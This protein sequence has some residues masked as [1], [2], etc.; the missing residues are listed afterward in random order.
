[1]RVHGVVEKE[2][3]RKEHIKPTLL[4]LA[5]NQSVNHVFLNFN[6]NVI[7][8]KRHHNPPELKQ[9]DSD[10]NPSNLF[11]GGLVA[12]TANVSPNSYICSEAVILDNVT[13]RS[14]S[15]ITSPRVFEGKEVIDNHGPFNGESYWRPI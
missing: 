1:M 7:E 2:V 3:L 10:N 9:F 4:K 6:G 8:L 11:K 15:V 12:T 5:K 14:G 13:V